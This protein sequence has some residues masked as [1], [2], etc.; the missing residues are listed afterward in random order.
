MKRFALSFWLAGLL[1]VGSALQAQEVRFPVRHNRLLKDRVGELIFNEIGIEYQ[2]RSKSVDEFRPVP[3]D[4]VV[5]VCDS[6]AEEC[7]VWLGPGKRVHLAS[8]IRLRP[9]VPMKKC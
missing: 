6:A 2:G 8:P 7:P 9:L 5:T 4:L 1:L 3:F